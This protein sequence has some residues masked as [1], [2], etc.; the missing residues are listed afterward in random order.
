M[1]QIKK[2]GS[3]GSACLFSCLFVCVVVVNLI[4]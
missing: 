4:M 2:N 1:L 3:L